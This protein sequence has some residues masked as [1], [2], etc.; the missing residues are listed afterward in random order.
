MTMTVARTETIVPAACVHYW[1]I[2]PP[3]APISKGVCKYC[4]EEKEFMN[5]LESQQ[6]PPGLY[7]WRDSHK[8]R[9][10]GFTHAPPL[11]DEWNGGDD[12]AARIAEDSI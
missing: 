11:H 7:T 3:D 4:G 1:V 12:N 9:S 5:S 10:Q 6:A 2:E 8:C